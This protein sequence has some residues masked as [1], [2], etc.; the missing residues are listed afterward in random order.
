MPSPFELFEIHFDDQ[1]TLFVPGQKIEGFL[2]LNVKERVQLSIL[3]LSF[4]GIITTYLAKDNE[5]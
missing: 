1:R 3:K 5:G 4:K 2:V